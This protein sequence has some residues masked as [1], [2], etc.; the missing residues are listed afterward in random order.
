M[1]PGFG[2]VSNGASGNTN[3]GE[4]NNRSSF[5]HGPDNAPM[6]VGSGYGRSNSISVIPQ[7][8]HGGSGE[9]YQTQQNLY[10]SYGNSFLATSPSP[11][12][13]KNNSGFGGNVKIHFIMES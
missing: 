8:T 9:E 10:N 4:Y 2:N 12:N 11:R 13:S 3:S 1:P 7:S 5:N 6:P